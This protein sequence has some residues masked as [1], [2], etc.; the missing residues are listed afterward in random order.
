MGSS[1]KPDKRPIK[2]PMQFRVFLR[3]AIGGRSY[4]DRLHIFRLYHNA[5]LQTGIQPNQG[6]DY[7]THEGRQKTTDA[8]IAF[9]N[10]NGVIESAYHLHFN[11]IRSWREF[12]QRQQRK[13]ALNSRWLKDKR[14]KILTLLKKRISDIS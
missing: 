1:G 13:D 10:L 12:T 8:R 2:F 3:L 6:E 14:K 7:S 5:Y 4:G 9:Y 11:N